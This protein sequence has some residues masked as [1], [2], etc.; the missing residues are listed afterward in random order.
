MIIFI[1]FY[2][3]ARHGCHLKYHV[4]MSPE[5]KNEHND[6]EYCKNPEIWEETCCT[7]VETLS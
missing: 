3:S 5:R 4:S 6:L 7:N 1:L 2:Y